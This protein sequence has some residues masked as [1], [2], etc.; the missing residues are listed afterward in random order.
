MLLSCLA[1]LDHLFNHSA[2]LLLQ[3]IEFFSIIDYPSI[4][5]NI[6]SESGHSANGVFEVGHDILLK[7]VCFSYPARPQEMVLKD[8]NVAIKTGT[9]VGIIGT[10]G[11]GKST[12]AA[13]L[14]RV[15]DPLRGTVQIGEHTVPEYNLRS[16]RDQI[17][18]VDQNPSLFSG[19][20]Y[21]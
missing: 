21:E 19:S 13:L 18:L 12:I 16:L 20:I 15:Y 9:T 14:F 11:S 6:Y 4:P 7:D 1:K 5:I 8:I 2:T 3:D 10:S 17:A